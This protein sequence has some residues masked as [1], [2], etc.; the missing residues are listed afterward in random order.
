M[1]MARNAIAVFTA[2]LLLFVAGVTGTG[3]AAADGPDTSDEVKKRIEALRWPVLERGETAWQV[4]VVKKILGVQT[5]TRPEL[6]ND[7]LHRAVTR[8]QEEKDLA[9]RNRVGTETWENLR[10]TFGVV[11]PGSTER[12]K[13]MAV[14]RALT[15]NGH[16][17]KVDGYYGTDTTEAVKAFQRKVGIQVDGKTGRFTF[18]ALICMGA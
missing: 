16:P 6:Y 10:Y 9:E 18:R 4:F 14:Q 15:K 17:V 11:R 1:S 13:V 8:Y 5:S 2:L 3:V 12:N 7:E